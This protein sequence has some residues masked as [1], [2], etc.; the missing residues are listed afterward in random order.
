[1]RRII[2]IL[3]LLLLT[4]NC[5]SCSNKDD[6]K[7]EKKPE[8][9]VVGEFHEDIIDEN[10][11]SG[12][13]RESISE[14]K[15]DEVICYNATEF[16]E[17]KVMVTPTDKQLPIDIQQIGISELDMGE[18][19]PILNK[20]EY[21]EE[22]FTNNNLLKDGEKWLDRKDRPE[23]ANIE[24]IFRLDKKLYIVAS[25]GNVLDMFYEWAF[26]CYDTENMKSKELFSWS[27]DSRDK[28]CCGIEFYNGK[29]F[30]SVSELEKNY[31][32]ERDL[33]SQKETIVF[34]TDLSGKYR[35]H[36]F[37]ESY[38]MIINEDSDEAYLESYIYYELEDKFLSQ[39]EYYAVIEEKIAENMN[40]IKIDNVASF[41]SGEGFYFFSEEF[42]GTPL[43]YE[44]DHF[45]FSVGYRI[46]TFDT[47]K[48]EHYFSS[49]DDIGSPLF[50]FD[51]KVFLRDNNS[52]KCLVPDMGL[53]YNVIEDV[54]FDNAV[55]TSAG[56]ICDL[57][58][59]NEKIYVLN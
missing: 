27:S 51:G 12:E 49:L 31:I 29:L 7:T 20:D 30:Y 54:E 59:G 52:V 24:K 46:D 50:A 56:I 53:V 41:Y 32:I 22:V 42:L 40:T 57:T 11:T 44:K 9:T 13:V 25:Y 23:K 47:T 35:M 1:M 21:F 10:M 4:V 34:E 6:I 33:S 5:Y 15:K 45:I 38:F 14:E 28:K 8:N 2:T 39:E 3:T 58:K 43:C 19:I 17:I 55:E 18:R 48:M 16:K 36:I 26:F 37:D